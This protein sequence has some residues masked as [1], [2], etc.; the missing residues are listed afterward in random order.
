MQ[1]TDSR[2]G[3]GPASLLKEAGIEMLVDLPGV[4]SN[5]QDHWVTVAFFNCKLTLQ[6][7]RRA[8]IT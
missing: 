7:A 8:L 5:L 1:P 3:I 4:G 2:I 6:P